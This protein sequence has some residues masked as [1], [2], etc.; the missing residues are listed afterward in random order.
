[1]SNKNLSDTEKRIEH[2]AKLNK[3]IIE[4]AD[5]EEILKQSQI[6]DMYIAKELNNQYISS[7]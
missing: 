4:G 1:M 3:L 2:T 5:F 6:V 7:K